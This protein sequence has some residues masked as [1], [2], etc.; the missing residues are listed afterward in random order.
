[1]VL[2]VVLE[3]GG[4]ARRGREDCGAHPACSGQK[5]LVKDEVS[6]QAVKPV[7]DEPFGLSRSQY[8]EGVVQTQASVEP[9]APGDAFVAVDAD[10]VCP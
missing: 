8:L 9:V 10:E 6:S 5:L 1:V 2:R 7:D 3:I 4:L